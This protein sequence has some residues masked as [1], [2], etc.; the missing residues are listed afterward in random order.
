[1]PVYALTNK[2]TTIME[3]TEEEKEIIMKKREKEA[4]IAQQEAFIDEM[5]DLI[6]R[7]NQAGFS[8]ATSGPFFINHA[9]RWGDREDKYIRLA[10][11]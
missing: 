5:N 9:E 10:R 8:L 3:I 6:K 7:I 4:H 2:K 11:V 1:M